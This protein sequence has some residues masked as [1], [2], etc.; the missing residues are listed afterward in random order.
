MNITVREMTAGDWPSVAAIYQ[1]GIA[2]GHATFEADPPASWE[3]FFGRKIKGCSLVALAGREAVAGWAA[4]SPISDRCV[5][6][7]VAEVSIYVDPAWRGKG[8]GRV[9]IEAAI[10]S[11]EAAGIWTLQAGIFPEN[12]A[13]VRLHVGHGFRLI[14]VRERLGRMGYGPRAGEWRDVLLFE[15][16]SRTTG[17]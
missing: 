17:V 12:E 8:V 14:G 1:A 4:L 16:R 15:R 9:L 5:Y 11:S 13:S 6:G 7:G 3:D 10:G 2:T